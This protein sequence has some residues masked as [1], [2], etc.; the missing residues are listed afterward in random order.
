MQVNGR[1]NLFK[2]LFLNE[3]SITLS[4]CA[5]ARACLLSGHW[6][7]LILVCKNELWSH[8]IVFNIYNTLGYRIPDRTGSSYYSYKQ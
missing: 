1:C 8:L 5:L 3:G 2:C 4:S 7:L 6:G